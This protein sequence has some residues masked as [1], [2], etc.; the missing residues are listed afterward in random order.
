MKVRVSTR[1][2]THPIGFEKFQTRLP[3]MLKEV[4]NQI[5]E[6]KGIRVSNGRPKAP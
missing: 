2:R 3:N 5:F 6:V 4:A 1:S